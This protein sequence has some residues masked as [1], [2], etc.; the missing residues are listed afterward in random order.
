MII[1]SHYLSV[2]FLHG[3]N[4]FFGGGVSESAAGHIGCL[5]TD[6]GVRREFLSHMCVYLVMCGG[7]WWV[8]A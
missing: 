1:A 7:A 8:S 4:L 6:S 3:L 2:R 5:E